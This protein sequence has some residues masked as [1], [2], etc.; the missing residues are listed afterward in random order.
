MTE[1]GMVYEGIW[2]SLIQQPPALYPRGEVGM[3]KVEERS[4]DDREGSGQ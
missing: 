3:K 1:R 2:V 4:L